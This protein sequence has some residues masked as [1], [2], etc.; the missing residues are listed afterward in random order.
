MPNSLNILTQQ[1]KP[2]LPWAEEHFKERVDGYPTNPGETYKIWPYY[3]N[4]DFNDKNFRN[5]KHEPGYDN[6]GKMVEVSIVNGPYQTDQFT[7][8]Y[9][10]RYWPKYANPDHFNSSNNPVF[11]H[12]NFGIRYVYG[13]LRDLVG[14]LIREPYT[15][16]AY[17][18]VWFP[19]DTGVLHGGR[20]P[21]S[22]GYHF[23]M[24]NNKLNI[25]YT[26]RACDFIRHFRNDIYLTVRL[27]M[28]V[29]GELKQKP[30]WELSDIQLGLITFD[31]ISLHIFE[32]EKNLI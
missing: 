9:M 5:F 4:T 15:R 7:H 23:I 14:L 13:D 31:C 16:Q 19:E 3:K 17:L 11:T 2:N 10:E 18:P 28:W 1:T 20:V 25:H 12:G 22:L 26:I 29:L 6:K 8:T 27:A 30:W 21:C 32:Q 24:R